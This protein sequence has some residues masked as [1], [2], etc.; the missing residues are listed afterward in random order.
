MV[1]PIALLLLLAGARAP[2][3]AG[4]HECA[5][6]LIERHEFP[7]AIDTLQAVIARNP[8]DTRALNLLGIALTGAGRGD[9][10]NVMFRRALAVDASFH[11]ARKNLAV[12]EFNQGNVVVAERQFRRVLA[13]LPS[14]EVAHLYLGEIEFSRRRLSAARTHYEKSG[15][16]IAASPDA[17]VH[18]AT[19]LLESGQRQDA[20]ALLE[21][22]PKDAAVSRFEAGVALGRAGA[23]ADAAR[24]FAT[25]RPGYPDPLAAG[26][27]ELLMRV[28][29][30]DRDG[31]L[32]LAGELTARQ[33]AGADVHNLAAR[34]YVA[35]GRIQEA[36]DALR[37]AA[38]LEPTQ[39]Q[40][41]VDLALICADHENFDLG[42]EIV[43]VGLR[44]LPADPTLHLQRGVL[45]V[46]KGMIDE[47]EPALDR[48]RALRPDSA[49]ATI[50]LAM[51]WMQSGRTERAVDLL[52]R[53]APSATDA[54]VP[55][56]LGVAL[57]RSGADPGDAAGTEA[58][59]AFEAAIRLDPA[60]AGPRGELGKLLLKRG[61]LEAAIVNLER[62]VEL[63]PGNAAPAYSLA[64]AYRLTGNTARAQELLAKVTALNA[65]ERGGDDPD[66]EL[67]RMVV[68]IV[69]E[70]SA[71]AGAAPAR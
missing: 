41:Y 9:D 38:R 20:V 6:A 48:A 69:R 66:R 11:A 5:V 47:A 14:D 23:H 18:Y 58:A 42:L 68:R 55:Y 35:A 21:R 70:G 26:Y 12:N 51:A 37:A 60:L 13:A 49:A 64:Q 57:V 43:D 45:L 62:A 63:E 32:A 40:H 56:M 10:G 52:R 2:C 22:L 36:Y 71:P 59:A 50:A 16:R 15:D 19:C 1:V 8:R 39:P 7:S 31:A 24:F 61:D 4:P 25:S 53:A 67:K 65:Q 29:A 27:N 54:V 30:G 28:E 3:D 44:Y 46:M 34:A 33:D 17:L